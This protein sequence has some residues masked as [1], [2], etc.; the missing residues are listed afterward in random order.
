MKR[1]KNVFIRKS[2]G[3]KGG[4]IYKWSP[5]RSVKKNN[6]T[7]TSKPYFCKTPLGGQGDDFKVRYVYNVVVVLAIVERHA[8]VQCDYVK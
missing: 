4:D 5:D 6:N 8:Y 2:I 7:K 3:P 1:D